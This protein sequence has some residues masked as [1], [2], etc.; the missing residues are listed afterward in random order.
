MPEVITFGCR[1]NSLESEVVKN[2]AESAGF[3]D[4]TI[5]FNSCAVTGEAERQ[6]RQAVRKSRRE[7]PD[8]T[9]IMTGC[10]AQISPDQYSGMDEVDFVIGN[11]LK[12]QPESWQKLRA[13]RTLVSDIMD[14]T[15]VDAHLM[16]DGMEGRSRGFLQVQTGCDHRCTFCIIPYGRGN[17]RSFAEEDIIRQARKL[18][19]SGYSELVLTG[20]DITSYGKDLSGDVQ[21]GRVMKTLLS[22]NADIKRLRLSSIDPAEIDDDLWDL[23]ES[24]PRLMPHLHI[25]LQAGDNMILKRMKRRHNREDVIRLCEKARRLRPDMVFGAD[26]IAGFPTETDEMFK[27]S[28]DLIEQ[29]NIVLLHVFPYSPRP[30][31]PASKM[32]QVHGGLR[33]ERAAKLRTLGEKLLEKELTNHINK[34]SQ[35]IVEKEKEGHTEHFLKVVLDKSCESGEIVTAKITGKQKGILKAA[36]VDV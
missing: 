31:T 3:G 30:G 2:L 34:T 13:E 20:V 23:I 6:L 1:L 16:I 9:I 8:S 15:S 24:E 17:S 7:H 25:S 29:C 26:I 19:S 27:Q 14:A 4:D 11:D 33:K 22:E 28:M 5:I 36:L 35:I 18:T 12:L 21:L 32:P 10:A